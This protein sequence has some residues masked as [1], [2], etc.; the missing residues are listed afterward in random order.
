MG[1]NL[2][3]LYTVGSAITTFTAIYA[4]EPIVIYVAMD[5]ENTTLV[6]SVFVAYYILYTTDVRTFL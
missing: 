1:F 4:N 2:F 6:L 3:L 5:R